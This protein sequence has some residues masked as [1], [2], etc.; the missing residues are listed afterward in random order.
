MARV[1]CCEQDAG[2]V[3]FIQLNL[4]APGVV[5]GHAAVDCRGGLRCNA[6]F[7]MVIWGYTGCG[8]RAATQITIVGS[9]GFA[10]AST[11]FVLLCELLC[12]GA[13]VHQ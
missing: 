2:G 5:K 10:S 9:R 11:S 4:V 7:V 1:A 12:R 3:F 13:V 6:N 8:W